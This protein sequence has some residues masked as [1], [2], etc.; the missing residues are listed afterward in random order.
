MLDEAGREKVRL[1]HRPVQHD[2]HTLNYWKQA[3]LVYCSSHHVV[4]SGKGRGQMQQA[5]V[6]SLLYLDHWEI[7]VVLAE[8]LVDLLGNVEPASA[9]RQSM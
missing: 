6:E 8:R 4:K 2:P 1:L 7:V 9:L 5:L 3:R